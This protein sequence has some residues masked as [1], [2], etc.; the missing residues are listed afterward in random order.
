MK[1]ILL[2]GFLGAGKTTFLNHLLEEFKGQRFGVLMNEFGE[3]SVDS[4]LIRSGDF[5]LLELTGGSV[6]CACLKENFI[7]GLAE[8]RSYELEYVFVESSGVVDPS[9]MGVIL[10]TV[11]KLGGKSYD[12]LGSL[13]IVDA[14]YFEETFEVLP[15]LKKQL[16]Y[17]GAVIINKT[18]LQAKEKIKS[19]KEK[20]QVLNP[21]AELLEAVFCN[22]PLKPLLDRRFKS[23]APQETVNT[24][25]SRPK[26]IMLTTDALVDNAALEKL[27]KH[28]APS[29][30][31]IKGFAKTNRGFFEISGVNDRIEITPWHKTVEK[32][33]IV[34]ISSVGIKVISLALNAWKRYLGDTP[35]DLQ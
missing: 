31:R 5:D 35:L 26:T 30:Y 10:E 14:L 4:T 9:N 11:T 8:L 24:W 27:L 13:C 18:D 21:E 1:L 34:V 6:F 22:V 28:I 20:I 2:T 29:A 25:E 23:T 32:T 7:K 12:Y 16:A 3:K 33:E 19:I 15:A 17:A